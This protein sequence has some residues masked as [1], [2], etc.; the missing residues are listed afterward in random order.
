MKALRFSDKLELTQIPIPRI[1]GETLVRVLLAG[2]CNTD[3]EITKGYAGFNGVPGHEFVGL[4]VESDRTD[5]I[6]KRVV[7]EINVGCGT[8]DLCRSDD[9]RHCPT[10]TVLGIKERDGAFAEFLSLPARNLLVVPDAISAAAAVFVEPLAAALN[11]VEQVEITSETRAAVLGDGKL[12]QLIARVLASRTP[13]LTLVGKHES[14]MQ[15][16]A[17]AG[18]RVSSIAEVRQPIRK[19]DIV[20]DATGAS[21]GLPL[22]L[23]LV[24]PTGTVVLKTTHHGTT[25]VDLS[26]AVVN[27]IKIVG[28]RC[29]RFQPALDLLAS[30]G[31]DAESLISDRFDIDQGLAAFS[32]AEQPDT[33]KILLEFPASTPG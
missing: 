30:G 18:V 28:S 6:G 26:A 25:S 16:A 27:E 33:F 4:V 31:L 2:I 13:N 5:L 14:K 15:K 7:G 22:A 21:G 32:R 23:D 10:R 3:L 8:C 29:G 9:S 11:I 17:A 12:G 24:R 20:V 19:F 1:P